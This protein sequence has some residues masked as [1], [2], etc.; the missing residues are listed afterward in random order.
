[1]KFKRTAYWIQHYEFNGR[2]SGLMCLVNAARYLGMH[3]PRPGSRK[4]A[5][6]TGLRTI[7]AQAKALNLMITPIE[8][9]EATDHVPAILTVRDGWANAAHRTLVIGGDGDHLVLVNF[10][11]GYPY[12]RRSWGVY[13]R[14][15]VE[16]A[17]GRNRKAWAVRRLVERPGAQGVS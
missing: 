2:I 6:L 14:K 9:D 7:Q 5:R 15:A 4:W 10:R 1:V 3:G 8:P 13:H 17:R 16:M 12:N 11:N